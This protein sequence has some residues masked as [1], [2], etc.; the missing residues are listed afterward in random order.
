MSLNLLPSEAKFQAQRMRI[1]KIANTSLWIIGGVWFLLLIISFGLS[2]F[3]SWKLKQLDKRYQTK[4]NDYKSRVDEITLT[5]KI[6]YQAKIVAKVL[7][8]R[9]E[10]G[11]SMTLVN[12]VFSDKVRVDDIKLGDDRSFEVNG[13]S[14]DGEAI[15]EIES[16]VNEINNGLVEGFSSADIASIEL[17]P[18][19]GW[20]FKVK[21]YLD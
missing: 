21:L 13:G 10:Y 3:L 5:Q 18:T 7:D 9:F 16:K 20:L 4:F 6:K 19:K 14:V 1:R 2:F 12:N 15:N 11:K 8:S 17:S